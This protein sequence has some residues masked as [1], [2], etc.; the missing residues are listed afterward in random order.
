MITVAEINANRWWP[1]TRRPAAFRTLICLTEREE[2][3]SGLA[4]VPTRGGI[5]EPIT[6]RLAEPVIGQIVGWRYE[7]EGCF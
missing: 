3:F 7:R 5:I 4:Y 2:E 6:N 1:I